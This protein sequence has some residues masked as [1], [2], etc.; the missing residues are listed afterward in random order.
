MTDHQFCQ[1]F[2]ENMKRCRLRA[3]LSRE[4]LGFRA[5]LHRTEIG[6]LERGVRMP[7]LDTILKLAGGLVV[8]PCELIADMGWRTG[9]F[10]EG[11]F[12]LPARR[13]PGQ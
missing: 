2:G 4:E 10:E 9:R 8:S 5:S 12:E 3:D 1:R 6:Q 7:R 13:E 11:A